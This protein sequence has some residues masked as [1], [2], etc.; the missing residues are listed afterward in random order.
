MPECDTCGEHVSQQFARVFAADDGRIHACP[1]CAS[2]AGIGE[3]TVAR[4]G[5]AG[6][7]PR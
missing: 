6:R 1:S 5:A 4:A 3:V 2:K 7:D